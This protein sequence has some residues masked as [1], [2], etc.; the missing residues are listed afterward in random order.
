MKDIIHIGDWAEL[1]GCSRQSVYN[2]L[3]AG[4]IPQPIRLPGQHRPFWTRKMREEWLTKLE[5]EAA[6]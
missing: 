6:A 4:L 1:D 2:R 5:A 3:A